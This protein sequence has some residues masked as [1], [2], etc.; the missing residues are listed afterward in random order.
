MVGLVRAR[1]ANVDGD[2]PAHRRRHE[3]KRPRPAVTAML[4]SH[5]VGGIALVV[6]AVAH[7]AQPPLRLAGASG[8]DLRR[9]RRSRAL[10]PRL[11][12]RRAG[13][14]KIPALKALAPTG[15]EAP[16]AIAQ[17]AVLVLFAALAVAAVRTA[18]HAGASPCLRLK[19]P[20]RSPA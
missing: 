12:R 1:H 7:H 9:L 11:R 2:V 19:T 17:L 14:L 13:F 5:I 4:P 15:S 16:F 6:L 3:C 10:C 8:L 18:R 20:R